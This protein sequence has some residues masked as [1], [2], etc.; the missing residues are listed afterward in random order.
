MT[1]TAWSKTERMAFVPAL[2][3]VD[4]QE[5]FCPPNGPLAVPDGREIFAV[6]NN[7]L[8]LPFHLKIATKDW[9]PKDHISFAKNHNPPNN[10]PFQSEITIANPKNPN[11]TEKTKLWPVHCEQGSDGAQLAIELDTTKV[12]M[13]FEKGMD[14]QVEMYSAFGA[15]FRDPVYADSGLK[16]ILTEHGITHVYVVGLAADYCV[17]YTALDSAEAGFET[18]I[19]DEGT[20]PIDPLAMDQVRWELSDAGVRWVS[21]TGD[22]VNRVRQL[23]PEPPELPKEKKP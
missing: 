23:L 7:L 22:E 20:K 21:V 19:I 17:K 12:T 16:N 2:I 1:R 15:P 6:V 9:H 14:K 11:E 8:D 10:V 3:I 5:D 18:V 13:V 4:F